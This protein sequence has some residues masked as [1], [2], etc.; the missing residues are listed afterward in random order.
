MAHLQV[1]VPEDINTMVDEAV[2]RGDY[3][4]NSAMVTAALRLWSAERNLEEI[5]SDHLGRKW[6]EAILAN[7][8]YH[9]PDPILDRL[10]EKYRSMPEPGA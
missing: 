1:E 8:P 4:S 10:E 7:G 5:G 6:D 3:E 9:D 2:S